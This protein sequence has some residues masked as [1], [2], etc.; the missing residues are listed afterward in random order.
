MS[1]FFHEQMMQKMLKEPPKVDIHYEMPK[2]PNNLE[3]PLDAIIKFSHEVEETAD[4]LIFKSIIKFVEECP[5]I[6]VKKISKQ[7][8][9]DALNAKNTLEQ[10]LAKWKEAMENI[11]TDINSQSYAQ[12]DSEEV[13]E[14]ID[15]HTEGLL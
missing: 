1:D 6:E 12:W 7:Y 11:K 9:I 4:E 2:S 8:L 14:I 3:N 5:I 13:I 10:K 15:K